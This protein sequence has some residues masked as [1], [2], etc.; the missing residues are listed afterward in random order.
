MLN[1]ISFMTNEMKGDRDILMFGGGGALPPSNIAMQKESSSSIPFGKCTHCL[2][3]KE[4]PVECTH[5]SLNILYCSRECLRLNLISHNKQCR[6][7]YLEQSKLKDR[8]QRIQFLGTPNIQSSTQAARLSN[9]VS[10]LRGTSKR[11]SGSPEFEAQRARW[12]VA[13][14]NE[15]LAAV[16][17]GDLAAMYVYAIRL[18]TGDGVLQDGW[19][20]AEY[21]KKAGDAGIALAAGAL[22]DLF[23]K[24]VGDFPCDLVSSSRWHLYAA[25]VLHHVQSF[26]GLGCALEGLYIENGM[27]D[28]S[29]L[30]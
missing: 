30:N 28:V 22:G 6:N 18:C 19:Q 1:V 12:R 10:L 21:L 13:P 9:A 4:L 8:Q 23:F 17:V 20:A 2:E 14:G 3:Q 15:L 5:C 27:K 24:G 11:V 16:N 26:F 25:E 29:L 7:S